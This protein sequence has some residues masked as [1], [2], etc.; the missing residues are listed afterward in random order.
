MAAQRAGTSL[1][2]LIAF[3]LA[4]ASERSI[5]GGMKR[6]ICAGAIALA[7]TLGTAGEAQADQESFV[8]DTTSDDAL[9]NGCTGAAADCS[10][11]G[12]MGRANDADPVADVDVVQFDSSVFDGS[13]AVPGEATIV[14]GSAISSMDSISFEA[15]CAAPASQPCV[16]IDGPAAD[17]AFSITNG[18][19]SLSRV[20]IFGTGF[21]G[22]FQGGTAGDLQLF[23]NWF[24]L[25]LD[26]TV[27]G[28][29]VGVNVTAG[30]A[31]IGVSVAGPNF[32]AGN[33]IGLQIFTAPDV[34][35]V[36]NRFGV[37]PNGTLAANS[38]EDID[39]SGNGGGGDPTDI[40]IGE[41][42][43]LTAACDA[44]CNVIA[45]GGGLTSKGI[46]L[47]GDGTP[48]FSSTASDV[49]ILGN[50]I[51]LDA[52]GTASTGGGQLVAV[53]GADQVTV[54]GNHLAGGVLGISAGS[55]ANDLSVSGNTIGT[56]SA[57]TALVD[58]TTAASVFVNSS[59]ASPALI[60]Q[61][62]IVKDAS[63]TQEAIVLGNTGATVDENAIGLPDVAGSGGAYGI[64]AEGADHLI[65]ENAI[66]S[67]SVEAIDLAKMSGTEVAA[68]DIDSV[69]GD[70]IV[71]RGGTSAS[72]LR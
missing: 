65:E 1:Q 32:F 67:T 36:N 71:V 24:G 30:H 48:N 6:G 41:T 4:Q 18:S 8:V 69:S 7:L 57:G 5:G 15:N 56:N 27:V 20:A 2:A 25:K 34:Q 58:G 26:G 22:I 46:N 45:A 47:A 12:A 13:E 44:G 11:R 51:G 29:G 50:H 38:V 17:N 31:D 23:D 64:A 28:N 19:F 33:G 52:A 63:N 55:S 49:D 42:P 3:M 9:V 35:V 72:T 66:A 68:N 21:Q 54:S 61:N 53:G 60:N 10:L 16:G 39:V 62:T 59:P 43:N 14:L 37:K 70:G 40:T